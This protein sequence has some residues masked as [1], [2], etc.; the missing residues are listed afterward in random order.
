MNVGFW[1]APAW[2]SGGTSA[3]SLPLTV[4]ADER[5]AARILGGG[6]DG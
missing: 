2:S 5:A 1:T 3:A 6:S 4:D